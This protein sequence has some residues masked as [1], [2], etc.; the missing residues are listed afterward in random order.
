MLGADGVVRTLGLRP[1][2]RLGGLADCA[3]V[4]NVFQMR[5]PSR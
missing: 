3:V 5:R 1:I 2:A 4:D